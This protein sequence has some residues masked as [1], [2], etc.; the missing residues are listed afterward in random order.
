MAK[1]HLGAFELTVD[2]F[3]EPAPSSRAA[4][5]FGPSRNGAYSRCDVILDL[6][7]GRP[8]FTADNLREGYL[9]A[10]PNDPAGVLMA[11]LKVRD[12][13][14]TFEKPRYITL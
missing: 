14:G 4:L 13:V 8:L 9:R 12:L 5:S 7:G 6:S 3:A 10:D 1:G 11:V 2:G